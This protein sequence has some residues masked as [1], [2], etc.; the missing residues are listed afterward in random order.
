M[1]TNPWKLWSLDGAPAPG[2]AE[3]VATLERVLASSPDHP[4]ANHYSHP[5]C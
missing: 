2:T 3:I 1:N 4:G 5:R